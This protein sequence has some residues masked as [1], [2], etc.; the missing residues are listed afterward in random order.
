MMQPHY[1]GVDPP[2]QA[3][4]QGGAKSSRIA[5]AADE[6]GLLKPTDSLRQSANNRT[7]IYWPSPIQ[8][9]SSPSDPFP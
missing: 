4:A 3:G 9:L 8:R 5:T 6:D 2:G 7:V 1:C